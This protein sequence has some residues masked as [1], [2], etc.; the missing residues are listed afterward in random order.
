MLYA[1]SRLLDRA[2]NRLLPRREPRR[3]GQF[4]LRQAT[5]ILT[6]RL[7]PLRNGLAGRLRVI[8]VRAASIFG[9]ALGFLF[10]RSLSFHER[11]VIRLTPQ[12]CCERSTQ[13]ARLILWAARS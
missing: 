10:L 1:V 9:V 7:S 4:L 12:F 5:F 2:W 6:P 3:S 8:A 11:F 13:H